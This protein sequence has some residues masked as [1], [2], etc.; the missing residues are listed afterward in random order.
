MMRPL[1]NVVVV[2]D[3]TLGL[4]SN[5][6][7]QKLSNGWTVRIPQS[8]QSTPDGFVYQWRGLPPAVPVAWDEAVVSAG[9]DPYVDAALGRL[10]SR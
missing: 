6:L 8:M 1:P 9:R 5:P 4:G 3:T 7:E 10:R 2:G